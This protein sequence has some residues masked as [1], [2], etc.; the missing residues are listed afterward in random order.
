M[1][2]TAYRLCISAVLA[3]DARTAGEAAAVLAHCN[4]V[5]TPQLRDDLGRRTRWNVPHTRLSL[6]PR[7]VPHMLPEHGAKKLSPNGATRSAEC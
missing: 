3:G 6:V 7:L 1:I 5:E 4:F 2:D